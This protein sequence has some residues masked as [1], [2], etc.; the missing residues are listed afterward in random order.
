M[1]AVFFDPKGVIHIEY[2]ERGKFVNSLR[3][4][5]ILGNLRNSIRLKGR[6]KLSS[7]I[8]LYHG[9][10]PAHRS[11]AT[12]DAISHHGFEI[13]PHPAYSPDLAPCDFHLF[14]QIKKMIKGHR[15]EG[16]AELKEAFEAALS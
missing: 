1:A 14:P 8:L 7:R 16:I 15:F 9:N 13:L 2:L 5:E 4:I 12:P 11:A 10:A 3:F 6:G